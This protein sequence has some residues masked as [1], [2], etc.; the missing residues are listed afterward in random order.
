MKIYISQDIATNFYKTL[1]IIYKGGLG[2][3]IFRFHRIFNKHFTKTY[4]FIIFTVEV[5]LYLGKFSWKSI[6]KKKKKGSKSSE[7]A[8]KWCKI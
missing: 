3:K 8:W 7:R 4:K 5:I 2:E 1:Q 6:L